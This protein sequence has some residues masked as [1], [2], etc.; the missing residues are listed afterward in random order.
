[1]PQEMASV[2]A[3]SRNACRERT[4]NDHNFEALRSDTKEKSGYPLL[5]TI[6]V[7][8]ARP[9]NVR[10]KWLALVLAHRLLREIAPKKSNF[11]VKTP[12]FGQIENRF[13]VSAHLK[14]R[15]LQ[16]EL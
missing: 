4:R 11:V 10:K 3:W 12:V 13:Q 7:N 14:A 2:L 1:M 8:K 16:A 9:L 15:F 6:V 5:A